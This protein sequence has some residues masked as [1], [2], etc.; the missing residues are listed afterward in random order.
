MWTLCQVSLGKVHAAVQVFP[1]L[2]RTVLCLQMV[3]AV[4]KE[5]FDVEV[6]S[7]LCS[8]RNASFLLFYN[9]EETL[10]GDG[11]WPPQL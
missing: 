7:W 3:G 9:L 11:L 1:S 8:S 10:C 4:L 5:S 6:Q 2:F